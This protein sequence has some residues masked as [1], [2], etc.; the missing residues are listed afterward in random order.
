MSKA[1]KKRSIHGFCTGKQEY[2]SMLKMSIKIV[3]KV[4]TYFMAGD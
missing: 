1:A 4:R 2:I 3:L